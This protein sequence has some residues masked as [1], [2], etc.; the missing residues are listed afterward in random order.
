MYGRKYIETIRLD[1]IL[2]YGPNSEAFHLEPLNVLIGRNASGK[3]NLIEAL[4]ILAAAPKDIQVP[5]RQGGGVHEWIWKGSTRIPLATIEATVENQLKLTP[6]TPL[7]YRLTFGELSGGF[8]IHEEIV[9]DEFSCAQGEDPE[10]YYLHRHGQSKISFKVKGSPDQYELV[11]TD[12]KR[13]QSI[14][15]QRVEPQFYPELGYLGLIF[16]QIRFYRDL[17]LG[18]DSPLRIP[19]QT[20]LPREYL[21][22]DGSNLSV[23]LKGLLNERSSKDW[24]FEHLQ[25]FYPSFQDI[26]YESVGNREQLF[27]QEDGLTAN[28]S[29]ARLSDGTLRFLCLLA[30][31]CSARRNPILPLVICIEEPETGLHPDVIPKLAKL[32]VEASERSQIFV[33]THSDILVDALSDTPEAVVICEKVDGATQLRRL[34]PDDLSVWLEKYRLGELW[35]S[36]DLGGNLY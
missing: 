19:Q 10:S 16:E 4:S 27:F 25:D 24:I 35:T 33:T 1:N 34:D 20:D 5:L 36:G 18:Q 7:R 32:L 2:S 17:S 8:A 30:V 9:E 13:D 11:E 3:S 15:S 6:P 14:L 21:L 23:I 12:V 22:E 29:T 31:L 28:V 26:R